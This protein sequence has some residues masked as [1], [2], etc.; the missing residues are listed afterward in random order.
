MV[1]GITACRQEKIVWFI[2]SGGWLTPKK[3]TIQ[4][5]ASVYGLLDNASEFVPWAQAHILNL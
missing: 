2:K 1:V 5:I 3:A 4:E